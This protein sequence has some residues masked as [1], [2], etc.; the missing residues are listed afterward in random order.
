MI[1]N[2]V[3]PIVSK[4]EKNCYRADC[5]YSVD[6]RC[7]FHESF[8]FFKFYHRSGN[9]NYGNCGVGDNDVR[10]RAELLPGR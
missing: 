4:H 7:V 6:P 9:S 1:A 5:R 3:A 2:K 8:F 10:H